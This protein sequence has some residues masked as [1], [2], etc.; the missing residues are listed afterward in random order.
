MKLEPISSLVPA[1]Y[2]PRAVDPA[3]LALVKLS[4]QKLGW[5]LPVY[6]TEGGEILSGHQRTHVAAELGYT[7]VPVVRLPQMPDNLRKA[8]NILFNRSTNDMDLDS[9]PEKLTQE[10]NALDVHALAGALEDFPVDQ[11]PCMA[12]EVKPV[13]PFLRINSGRWIPY[14]L[15]VA[16]SLWGY[17]VR[18]P[19]VVDPEGVVVNGIGRLQMLAEKGMTHATFLTLTH[20]QAALARPLLNL[21]SMN[22]DIHTKYADLL[23]FNSFRRAR[24]SRAE[25]G[26]GFVFS[27]IGSTSANQFDIYKPEHRKAWVK[28]HG[29]TVLD[30]GAGHLQESRMLQDNGID[31][32]PF[33]PYRLGADSVSIDKAE[34]LHLA[35]GFLRAVASGKRW[36]SIF[37]SSVLNSVPFEQD[38][39]HVLKIVANCCHP[40]TRVYA[41]AS[42]ENQTDLRNVKAKYFSEKMTSVRKMMLNYE[43]N[44]MLGEIS[45]SPKVQKYHTPEEFYRL[46]K[47]AFAS[48]QVAYECSV[49]VSAVAQGNLGHAGL[50]E[51]IEF[52]FNLPYP[53]GSRMDLVADAIA[54]FEQRLKVK[55]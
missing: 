6:A 27:V 25:L 1:S 20:A 38:R 32:T 4:L 54:A 37:I 5:L 23:R 52:E 14:A 49:N 31:V 18:M 39:K 47:S 9:E 7:Q 44:V 3:R 22:F 48:V 29:S 17:K 24:R 11:F 33:E 51:A 21:L 36:S 16:K 13:E 8:V 26:R 2:N 50:R 28:R 55:L 35:R 34:S 40:E 45:D 46:F 30:F 12:G 42:S 19:I 41:V 10:L 43:T 15:A 53:D